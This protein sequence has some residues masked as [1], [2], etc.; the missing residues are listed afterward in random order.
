MGTRVARSC[1][2]WVVSMVEVHIEVP[3]FFFVLSFFHSVGSIGGLFWSIHLAFLVYC[4]VSCE[5]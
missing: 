1:A 3:V 4:I 5:V 2:P